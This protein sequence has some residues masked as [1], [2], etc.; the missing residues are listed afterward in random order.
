MR[1]HL[2]NSN[3]NAH[4]E[5]MTRARW[6][7][8]Q[9]FTPPKGKSIYEA[10]TS[11]STGGW[12]AGLGPSN[13]TNPNDPK[14]NDWAGKILTAAS[15]M[16]PVVGPFVATGLGASGA[17]GGGTGYQGSDYGNKNWGSTALGALGG[18]GMGGLGS[19]IGGAVSGGLK[20]GLSGI[21]SGFGQGLSNYGSA[22]AAPFKAIGSA[23]GRGVGTTGV[24]NNS[25][26]SS[27]AAKNAGIQGMATPISELGMGAGVG[28]GAGVGIGSSFNPVGVNSTGYQGTGGMNWASGAAAPASGVTNAVGSA[29][30]GTGTGSA[31]SPWYAKAFE[32]INPYQL[33]I[34]GALSAA[35]SLMG[36]E[37]TEIPQSDM[38]GE[39]TS[40]LLGGEG[41]SALGK[42]GREQLTGQLGAEFQPVPDEYYNASKRRMDEAYD[43]AEQDF[44][45]SYKGLRPGANVEND[46]AFQQGINKIRQDRARETSALASELDYRRESDYY[47]RKVQSINSA[48]NLDQ[49]TMTDYISLAQM[50]AER[51]A[52]NTGISIG[53]AQKFKDIFGDLGGMF[54]RKG[55]GLEDPNSVIQRMK[56][57]VA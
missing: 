35:P 1:T 31:A 5:F 18:Y 17:L 28:A 48:L 7:L 40:R 22:T 45:T 30:A 11:G 23:F 54:M 16:I 15:G 24:A 6:D 53:E 34:G 32:G 47:D 8:K 39:A 9:M 43:K 33:A 42:L 20:G 51:L 41:I 56:G 49:Q 44:A 19:G 57:M 2:H 36:G 29:A 3:Q 13:P 52:T 46:S 4:M 12:A 38:F 37:K 10:A 26:L 21:G 14:G 27:L 55:L 50:D 25:Y